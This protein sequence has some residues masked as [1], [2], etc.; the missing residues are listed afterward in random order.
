MAS[1]VV[2]PVGDSP[3]EF[4][5]RYSIRGSYSNPLGLNP[6]FVPAGHRAGARRMERE[7]DEPTAGQLVVPDEDQTAPEEQLDE[8]VPEAQ[9][10]E[11][12]AEQRQLPPTLDLQ[13]PSPTIS[14]FQRNSTWSPRWR[15]SRGTEALSTR[16]N[17]PTSIGGMLA[18]GIGS[19]SDAS[20]HPRSAPAR[21]STISVTTPSWPPAPRFY[22]PETSGSTW[23]GKQPEMPSPG[24][25]VSL[26]SPSSPLPPDQPLII[27]TP[28]G[29]SGAYDEPTGHPADRPLENPIHAPRPRRNVPG[30][31]GP[32]V[33]RLENLFSPPPVPPV[34]GSPPA[35]K[36]SQ[37]GR[38]KSGV[39][40]TVTRRSVRVRPR[41]SFKR[42]KTEG[43]AGFSADAW[44][45]G[46]E[47]EKGGRKCV[48]M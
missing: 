47:D 3:T 15:D 34:P 9:P 27:S 30:T 6:P 16:A 45:E 17:P 38:R 42:K 7:H 48:V 20:G 36:Q 21:A 19:P 14:S 8:A 31:P 26:P 33:G 46:V 44:A 29:L 5:Y 22:Q 35:R 32:T 41:P 18:T 11:G 43:K 25:T 10:A 2:S 24:T 28:T 12:R 13:I 4:L 40:R 39:R 23:R 37:L 1:L